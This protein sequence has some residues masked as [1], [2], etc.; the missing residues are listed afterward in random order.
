MTD[1]PVVVVGAGVA[2]L[3][4]V[5]HLRRTDPD[6]EVVL[7]GDEP[8]LPYNRPPLSKAALT[9]PLDGPP[10]LRP[11]EGYAELGVAPI[12]ATRATGLDAGRREVALDDGTTL[13][14]D[15]LV[16][17]TGLVPRRL[18]ALDGLPGVHVL[19]TWADVQALRADLPETGGHVTVVGAGVL[20][21]ETAATLRGTGHDVALLEAAAHP[22][23]RVVGPALGTA[24]ADLHRRHDVDL[25][26]GALLQGARR[27]GK[28]LVLDLDDGATLRSDVVLVATGASPATDWLRDS[29]VALDDGVLVDEHGRSSLPHVWAVGDVARRPHPREAGTLRLEHW[30]NATETA[31]Q[32]AANLGVGADTR[33][34]LTTPPYFWS[35]QF[36]MKLQVAGLPA[37]EDDLEVVSGAVGAEDLLA[38]AHRAGE[39]TGVV[40]VNQPGALLRS[41]AALVPG[42]TLAGLLAAAPWTPRRRA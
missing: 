40:A 23:A 20:G 28:R 33:T 21:A 16:I 14:Y 4:V 26:C 13:G 24:I 5:E 42:T 6:R 3:R 9:G 1:R 12:L 38:V 27:D 25:R 34:A 19:R 11:A 2:G 7:V 31:Q 36:T 30:T 17:A 22:L 39:V 37:P 18:P 29:G 35:D 15:Q 10:L 41:R 32:V 8:H